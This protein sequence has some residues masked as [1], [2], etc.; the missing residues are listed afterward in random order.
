MLL[1]LD[2]SQ[3]TAK[4]LSS[5]SYPEPFLDRHAILRHIKCFKLMI[6]SIN[7]MDLDYCTLVGNQVSWSCLASTEMISWSNQYRVPLN[8]AWVTLSR[9]LWQVESFWIT[10]CILYS[11]PRHISLAGAICSIRYVAAEFDQ[12][13]FLQL[14]HI[15]P[16]ESEIT[17]QSC[18]RYKHSFS[19]ILLYSFTMG[20]TP[21][22][23]YAHH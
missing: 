21:N 20:E 3:C 14:V 6:A 18:Y 15:A 11:L 23:P 12:H 2:A 16:R 5:L 22:T 17:H 19:V 8:W 9:T 4:V 13:F 10:T 1:W 7:H